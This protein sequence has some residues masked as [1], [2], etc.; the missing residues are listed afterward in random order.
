ML[1]RK[2]ATVRSMRSA[3]EDR[4]ALAAT[5]ASG[6][7]MTLPTSTGFEKSVSSRP[8]TRVALEPS[9]LRTA[10]SCRRFTATC[11]AMPSSPTE[12]MTNAAMARPMNTWLIRANWR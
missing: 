12:A 10:T 5:H 8:T 9:V 4:Y 2:G 7:A 1:T 6:Q 11:T 3:K